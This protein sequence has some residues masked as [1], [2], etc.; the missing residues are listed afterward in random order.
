MTWGKGYY[1]VSK[2]FIQMINDEIEIIRNSTLDEFNSRVT[3]LFLGVI[4][5][6]LSEKGHCNIAI[7][8]GSTPVPVFR[9]IALDF[10]RDLDW[11]KVKVFW[12]DERSV[13]PS[14]P[15]SNFG[16]A[17]RLLLKYLPGVEYFRMKGEIDSKKAAMEY[18]DIMKVE[19]PID[20]GF[21]V[22]DLM[23]M[24]M[25]EDGHTASLFPDT[26]ILDEKDKWVDSVWV[27][28]KS[29]FRISLTIPVIN[30]SKVRIFAFYGEKKK[31]LF[32]EML[33]SPFQKYPLELLDYKK[34]RNIFITFKGLIDE[35]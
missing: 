24:G 28:K 5:K 32:Q 11:S 1:D 12:V 9:R 3:E 6:N 27:D 31:R 20:S 26:E 2:L 21:P 7:S 4:R 15:E 29:T 23:L 10:A 35:N 8:G 30:N 25:G 14:H 34:Q 17:R 16:N 18:Q 33:N 13:H 19:L 22:F